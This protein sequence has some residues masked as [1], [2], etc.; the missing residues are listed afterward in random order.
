MYKKFIAIIV[1]FLG[2]GFLLSSPLFSISE[3]VIKG[4]DKEDLEIVNLTGENIFLVEVEPI[5]EK[6]EED[7]YVKSIEVKKFF[8]DKISF[9]ISYNRPVAALINNEGYLVFNKYN[10]II[11]EGL[12]DNRYKVPVFCDVPYQFSE[13]ELTLSSRSQKILDNLEILPD[14]LREEISG[15]SF[16][17][18]GVNFDMRGDYKVRL[19][20]TDQLEQKF[21]ILSSAW[22]EGLL[23]QKEIEYFDL[24][25]PE[26]PVIKK[27]DN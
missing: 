3:V 1:L 18:I 27:N 4:Y 13:E 20:S 7:P 16:E 25:A 10:E 12:D 9:Q 11:A 5:L 14:S 24:T 6:L 17:S 21:I 8:P 22:E 19:G 15:I 23:N 26:R 2:I